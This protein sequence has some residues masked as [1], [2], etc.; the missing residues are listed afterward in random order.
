M[1]SLKTRVR[2]DPSR[3]RSGVDLFVAASLSAAMDAERDSELNWRLVW[4]RMHLFESS[5]LVGDTSPSA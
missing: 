1:T 4:V 2:K 3:V 5:R